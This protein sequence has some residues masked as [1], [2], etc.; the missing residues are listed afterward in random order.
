MVAYCGS[1]LRALAAKQRGQKKACLITSDKYSYRG[2][3]RSRS[4]IILCCWFGKN[5][6][7]A[8]GIGEM[9]LQECKTEGQHQCQHEQDDERD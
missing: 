5:N 4:P 2:P 9:V 3:A 7:V 8:L 6:A 1:L